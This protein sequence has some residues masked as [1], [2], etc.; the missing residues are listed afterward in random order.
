MKS[1]EQYAREEKAR[2]EALPAEIGWINKIE[3]LVP[4]ESLTEQEIERQ[5]EEYWSHYDSLEPLMRKR[6]AYLLA[7]RG[8]SGGYSGFHSSGFQSEL[9]F[10]IKMCGWFYYHGDLSF[11]NG[12]VM[13]AIDPECFGLWNAQLYYFA[14][15]GYS[16]NDDGTLKNEYE[17][18]EIERIKRFSSGISD[19]RL[20]KLIC[21]NRHGKAA[22]RW[23]L[24]F[25]IDSNA[26][27][28]KREYEPDGTVSDFMFCLP[29]EGEFDCT[30]GQVV[31]GRTIALHHDDFCMK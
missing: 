31:D 1:A 30:L 29:H 9:P 21:K 20:E 12:G 22:E 2:M 15:N 5:W 26:I 28:K 11:K 17:I 25:R 13:F 16:C 19:F 10:P 8:W 14:D 18:R 27:K 6:I 7:K 3:N 24:V 4:G 23:C